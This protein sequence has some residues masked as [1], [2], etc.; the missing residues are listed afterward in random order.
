MTRTLVVVES[1][2]ES[3]PFLFLSHNSAVHPV[4]IQ[5]GIILKMLVVLN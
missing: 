5:K 1:F 3:S 2:A 4:I